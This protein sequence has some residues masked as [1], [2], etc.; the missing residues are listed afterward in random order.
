MRKEGNEWA[1]YASRRDGDVLHPRGI[2]GI[3]VDMSTGSRHAGQGRA[4]ATRRRLDRRHG[5]GYSTHCHVRRA[6][7]D[8]QTAARKHDG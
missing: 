3:D 7:C 2:E 6:T 1:V 5:D 4:V 8:V